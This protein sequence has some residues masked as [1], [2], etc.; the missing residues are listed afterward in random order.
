MA[1]TLLAGLHLTAHDK[2]AIATIVQ[3]GWTHGESARKAYGVRSMGDGFYS[4]TLKADGRT[5]ALIVLCDDGGLRPSFAEAS[6]VR[7][8][9][10]AN[11]KAASDALNAIPGIGAGPMGLTPDAVKFSPEYGRARREY[12]KAA[13]ALRNLTRWIVRTYPKEARAAAQAHRTRK[14]A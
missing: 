9:W 5:H 11:A 6:K 8:A 4:V 14:A 1:V 12:D 10:D 13:D 7:D 3:R 2:A